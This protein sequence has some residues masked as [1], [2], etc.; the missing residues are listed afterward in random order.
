MQGSTNQVCGFNL[1]KCQIWAAKHEIY[2]NC[3]IKQ[4]FT[5]TSL[6]LYSS[7]LVVEGLPLA[8]LQ[9]PD[10]FPLFDKKALTGSQEKAEGIC[11]LAE[12]GLDTRSL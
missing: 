11:F 4:T 7:F 12:F 5:T 8:L 6:W 2:F 1:Q 9:F 3:R 10:G